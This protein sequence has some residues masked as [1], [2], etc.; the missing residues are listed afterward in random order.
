[1]NIDIALEILNKMLIKE[2]KKNKKTTITLT[3]EEL[4]IFCKKLLMEVKK[5]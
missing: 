3:K 4:I 1:M 5:Y 2:H